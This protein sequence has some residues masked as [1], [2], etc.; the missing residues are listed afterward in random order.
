[1]LQFNIILFFNFIT[2]VVCLFILFYRTIIII[3]NWIVIIKIPT[4]YDIHSDVWVDK[5]NII[6]TIIII[7]LIRFI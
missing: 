7:S 1:M 4:N 3:F 6:I 2:T 5:W